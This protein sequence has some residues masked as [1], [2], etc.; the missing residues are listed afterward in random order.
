MEKKEASFTAG[1]NVNWY[2]Q[3]GKQYGVS[4]KNEE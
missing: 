1:G 2:I 3:Y 4:F